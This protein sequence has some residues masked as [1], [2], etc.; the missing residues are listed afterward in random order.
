MINACIS[1]EN[2]PGT[3]LFVLSFMS[4]LEESDISKAIKELSGISLKPSVAASASAKKTKSSSAKLNVASLKAALP[5]PQ[6]D[7][8]EEQ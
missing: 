1:S 6:D 5:P 3:F 4:N 2:T 8:E 7:E